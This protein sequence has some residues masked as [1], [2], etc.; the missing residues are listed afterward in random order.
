MLPS[1]SIIV[2]AYNEEDSLVH[3]VLVAEE[4][5]RDHVADPLEW[6]LVD[7][8]STDG[9]WS[10]MNN[11]LNAMS[12][13]IPL[14]HLTNRG[15]GAA[16]WT[17]MARATAEWCTWMPA[18]GQFK[19]CALVDMIDHVNYSDLVLLMRE[20]RKR[21]WQRQI[22]SLGFYG[23][24]RVM[25][26]FNIYGFSG[27]FLVRRD[28]VQGIPLHSATAVQNYVVAIH[29]QKNGY[30]IRQT[31]TVV[32]PRISGQSKVANLS[33]IL[34]SFYDIVRLRLVV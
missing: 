23:W 28:I 6:I 21:S 1:L 24:I 26:G 4:E 29:C 18:D 27:I 9:T 12:G 31:Y 16:V 17:G 10:E 8:G 32:Q 33:T 3:T 25:L 22:L 20:E 11:L 15:L 19:A 34:K 30:R 13:V 7:D 5:L 2:P 14:K